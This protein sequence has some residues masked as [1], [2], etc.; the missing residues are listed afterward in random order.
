MPVRSELVLLRDQSLNEGHHLLSWELATRVP[1]CH[2]LVL[3][4]INQSW[5]AKTD[6]TSLGLPFWGLEHTEKSQLWEEAFAKSM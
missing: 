2:Q 4:G 6:E 1:L 5:S 3:E